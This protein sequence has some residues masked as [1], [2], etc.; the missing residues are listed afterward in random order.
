MAGPTTPGAKNTTPTKGKGKE[1]AGV[2]HKICYTVAGMPRP[3]KEGDS[4][5]GGVSRGPRKG[6]V[7]ARTTWNLRDLKVGLMRG[8]RFLI[9]PEPP[10]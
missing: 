8:Y 3:R 6:S 2:P 4:S 10:S 5:L 9:C 1:K 7:T